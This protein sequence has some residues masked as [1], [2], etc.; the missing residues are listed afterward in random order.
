MI[1]GTVI[2]LAL[3]GTGVLGKP[4]SAMSHEEL[5][6][7]KQEHI[8]VHGFQTALAQAFVDF[9]EE[10]FGAEQNLQKLVLNSDAAEVPEFQPLQEKGLIEAAIRRSTELSTQILSGNYAAFLGYLRSDLRDFALTQLTRNPNAP[11]GYFHILLNRVLREMFPHMEQMARQSNRLAMM[12]G[13]PS[14]EYETVRAR[15]VSQIRVYKIQL[16]LNRA[17]LIVQ[18]Y[19]DPLNTFDAGKDM[20]FAKEVNEY[21]RKE[22]AEEL[23]EAGERYVHDHVIPQLIRMYARKLHTDRPAAWHFINVR[24]NELVG[25]TLN[26]EQQRAVFAQVLA[27]SFATPGLSLDNAEFAHRFRH[28]I[29]SNWERQGLHSLSELERRFFYMDYLACKPEAIAD[30]VLTLDMFDLIARYNGNPNNYLFFLRYF[31]YYDMLVASPTLARQQSAV[32]E[33]LYKALLAQRA[34]YENVHYLTRDWLAFIQG[35]GFPAA[36]Q[37]PQQR[38]FIP[39]I[40]ILT[41]LAFTPKLP[42][43]KTLFASYDRDMTVFRAMSQNNWFL[44]DY[45]QYNGRL[46]FPE[47]DAGSLA[48]IV[49]PQVGDITEAEHAVLS[50]PASLQVIKEKALNGQKVFRMTDLD[51]SFDSDE[52]VYVYLREKKDGACGDVAGQADLFR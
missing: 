34:L 15:I 32:F 19:S 52:E 31:R 17:L 26:P 5:M 45:R 40:T 24:V 22:L 35:S 1:K 13:V 43:D 4:I 7:V 39:V 47:V 50:N 6:E 41:D 21:I 38:D 49:I 28:F 37:G 30:T 25:L 12:R 8:W 9:Y 10:S 36:F 44:V 18:I 33:A 42:F 23:P 51:A 27:Q 20:Y 46:G 11:K 3:L 2:I 16:H 48:S 14:S 29:V